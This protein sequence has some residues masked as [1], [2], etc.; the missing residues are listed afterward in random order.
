M[1]RRIP[2]S[3]PVTALIGI[4][5]FDFRDHRIDEA[6]YE[7]RWKERWVHRARPKSKPDAEGHVRLLCPA[8]NPWPLVRCEQKPASVRAETR[9]RTRIFLKSDVTANPPPS[10]T[11]RA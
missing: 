9:G 6:T 2:W 3:I 5:T 4:A 10:R 1:L 8:A 11:N 7:A